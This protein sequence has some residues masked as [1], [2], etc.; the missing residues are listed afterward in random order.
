MIE[1]EERL[2][3]AKNN[4]EEKKKTLERAEEGVRRQKLAIEANKQKAHEK[5]QAFSAV[6]PENPLVQFLMCENQELQSTGTM[7]IGILQSLVGS[8]VATS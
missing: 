3:W 5:I 7:V 1:S 4:V 6:V 8:P 2:E